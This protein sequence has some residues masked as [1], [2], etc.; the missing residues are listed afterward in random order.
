MRI[1]TAQFFIRRTFCRKCLKATNCKFDTPVSGGAYQDARE[2]SPV[3]NA[4]P[5]HC[6]PPKIRGS[7]PLASPRTLFFPYLFSCERKDRAAGGIKQMQICHN[8]PSVSLAADSSLYTREPLGVRRRRCSKYLRQPLSLGCAEPAPLKGEP[9]GAHRRRCSDR[10]RQPL[11]QPA[12]DSSPGRGA[13]IRNPLL[14][15]GRRG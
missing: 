8:N 12:A 4:R 6:G 7:M 15:V 3:W 11:S 13:W 1:R 5:K 14:L 2:M 10:G 9:R